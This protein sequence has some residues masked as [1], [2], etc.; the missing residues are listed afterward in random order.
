M[1]KCMKKITRKDSVLKITEL[2]KRNMAPV[3]PFA[4]IMDM[5]SELAQELG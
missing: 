2:G 1:K 5:Q 4:S 3:T